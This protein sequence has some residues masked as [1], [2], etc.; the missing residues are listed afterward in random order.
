V[1]HKAVVNDAGEVVR[2]AMT[3][4]KGLIK[5]PTT[6][7]PDA[8]PEELFQKIIVNFPELEA[9]GLEKQEIGDASYALLGQMKK[10]RDVRLHYMNR[11]F[12]ASSEA[13]LF[14]NQLPLPLEV[15]E[16]KHCFDISGS[17]MERLKP[18]PELLKL[19]IDTG[20][21]DSSAV[22][23]IEQSPKLVNLQI[24]RTRMTDFDLQRIFAACPK[25]RVL[26]IRPDQQKGVPD[27]ISG[28]SLR[29]LSGCPELEMLVLGME[30]NSLPWEECLEVLASLPNLK[31]LQINVNGI[32]DLSIDDPAIQKLHEAR[33]DLMIRVNG[34][35][36]GG[37]EG[38]SWK[39][40]DDGW[41]WDGGVT[42]HG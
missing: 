6:P 31:Q 40:E 14:I 39:Q 17:C 18:Q 10:L 26:L 24:H 15:L 30:W 35:P 13:P 33:P 32:P 11:K 4:H 5:N 28:R 41:D 29:G 12:G 25:L 22:G 23:F 38:Q 42:T 3:N 9:I 1:L 7:L 8:M 34:K 2:L 16:I 21:A 19:E 27:R 20:Y 37:T 36:L